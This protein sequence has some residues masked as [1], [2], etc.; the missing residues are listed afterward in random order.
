ML[1]DVYPLATQNE[2][3]F[4]NDQRLDTFTVYSSSE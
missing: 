3:K 1:T 4:T 2:L